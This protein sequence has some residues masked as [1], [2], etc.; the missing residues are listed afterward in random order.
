MSRARRARHETRPGDDGVGIFE[1]MAAFAVFMICFV[2]LLQLLP[3]GESVITQSANQR[4][5]ASVINSTL[6]NDQ[7]TIVPPSTFSTSAN[8]APSWATAT[9]T[10]TTQSGTTFEIYTVQG[11]CRAPV[12]P[13][14]GTVL[15]SDQ[16]SYHVVV[17][18]GW[19]ANGTANSTS[20]I[21]VDSTELATVTG[22]PPVGTVLAECPL[23]LT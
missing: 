12:A 14:N 15:A 6:Q 21:I 20:N 16:P 18:I 19:G 9:R 5:A 11:W 7:T 8:V 17:K 1:I 22:A 23:G 2:P 4:L 10:A 13:G 3:E